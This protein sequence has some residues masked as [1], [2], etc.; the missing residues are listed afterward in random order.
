M[1]QAVG[2]GTYVAYGVFFNSLITEF[3]WS[4]AV[5]SGAASLAFFLR[6]LL[7]IFVGRLNDTY[8][9]TR[10]MGITS[11]FFGAGLMMMSQV[12]EMWQL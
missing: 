1:I 7:A 9:P 4:R 10:L 6:G 5:I 12:H 2:V 8:G 11:L 3:Q